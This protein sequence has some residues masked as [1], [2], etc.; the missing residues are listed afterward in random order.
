MFFV[1]VADGLA[2][3]SDIKWIRVT[4]GWIDVSDTNKI[5]L[6]ASGGGCRRSVAFW[7]QLDSKPFSSPVI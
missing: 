1:L 7:A 2:S 6:C 3:E 5:I 4:L